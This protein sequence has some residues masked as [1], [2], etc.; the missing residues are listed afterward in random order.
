MIDPISASLSPAAEL[1]SCSRPPV[2]PFGDLD[3]LGNEIAELSAHLQ[4]ATYR[5]L[6]LIR[7]FDE[8]SGW[9]TGFRS[10]AHW[11]NWRIGLDMG[12]AREKVRVARALAD[13]PEISKAMK[14]G[15]ISYSKVRALTRVATP[16]T[17]DE[18]LTFAL[19]GTAAH[20]ER[21]IRSW[22]RVDRLEAMED[23]DRRL[24]N[25]FLKSYFDEDGMLVVQA[26]LSPEV[27]AL[28]LKAL[29]AA[30]EVLYQ[31][32]QEEDGSDWSGV[33][34]EQRRADALELLAES[35]LEGGLDPGTAGDRYQVV[36]H[37]NS[38]DSTDSRSVVHH[39]DSA[40]DVAAETSRSKHQGALAGGEL[41]SGIRVSAETSRRL[42]CD[43]GQVVMT[44][45]SEGGV[46]DVGRKTRTIHPALRRA[47]KNRDGGCRFPGCDLDQCDAHHVRHWADGGRTKL[48][49]LLL[50]CRHHH[51]ALHEGG[52]RV[53]LAADGSSRFFT[54]TG[55]PIS[56]A[57]SA[58]RLQ[59]DPAV[60]LTRDH[61]REGL[62]IDA[63]TGFPSWEGGAIDLN[64]AI[65]ALRTALDTDAGAIESVEFRPGESELDVSA[66][67]SR[68]VYSPSP[69]LSRSSGQRG[70][71]W[72]FS[73]VQSFLIPDSPLSLEACAFSNHR[74]A[75]SISPR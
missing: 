6:V 35:A 70:S 7:E 39:L 64:H 69:T 37:V 50:L 3:R 52:F 66:E 19:A 2:D 49:N 17:E 4:A 33:R 41:E 72:R 46:L 65:Q 29:E 31:Q 56:E 73:R 28:F 48:D 16:E 75:S 59:G 53:K 42:G 74:K 27:G 9:N 47:L 51:R 36:V 12:A 21:L 14:M 24:E 63:S 25:R 1:E 38:A 20:V 43:C 61:W 13:L 55:L 62:E 34:A 45:G 26:R 67:T 68:D 30:N 18:L 60:E 10:C 44:H 58:P 11:L 71:S 40:E 32:S 8:R 15:E 23:D 22:R 5:L 54:P 57:P